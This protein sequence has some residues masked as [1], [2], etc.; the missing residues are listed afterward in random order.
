MPQVH[1]NSNRYSKQKKF[2]ALF[3]EAQA[4]LGQFT[5]LMP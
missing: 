1:V 5:M 4:T 3:K 2:H